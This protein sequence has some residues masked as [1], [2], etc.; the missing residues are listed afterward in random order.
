MN[1]GL[2]LQAE[3]FPC[4]VAVRSGAAICSVGVSLER[5]ARVWAMLDT[6]AVQ[7]DECLPHPQPITAP[8]IWA[9]AVH[10]KL[11]GAFFFSSA[12]SGESPAWMVLN[13][14]NPLMLGGV[15]F[16]TAR[17]LI[18]F[19]QA[20]RDCLLSGQNRANH[21]TV[22]KNG[23]LFME[24]L[25]RRTRLGHFRLAPLTADKVAL[26]CSVPRYF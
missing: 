25:R 7:I 22:E 4:L 15:G 8:P 16:A 5:A 24:W 26:V 20:A 13:D 21:R 1:A 14:G 3:V 12:K 9:S 19:D 6:G 17:D 11:S 2:V 23:P 18:A 10:G